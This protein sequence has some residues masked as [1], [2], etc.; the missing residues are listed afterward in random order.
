MADLRKSKE[1][2]MAGAAQAR[3]ENA[4]R[5]GHSDGV[6]TGDGLSLKGPCKDFG[7]YSEMGKRQEFES[8]E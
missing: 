8:E 6:R 4:R 1:A 2:A 3:G 7:F 5:R